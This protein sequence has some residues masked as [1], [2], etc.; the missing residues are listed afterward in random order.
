MKKILLATSLLSMLT[1]SSY[2]ASVQAGEYECNGAKYRLTIRA[3]LNLIKNGN[4]K[5]I[6]TLQQ[7]DGRVSDTYYK[8]GKWEE[9]GDDTILVTNFFDSD[10]TIFK[11][12]GKNLEFDANFASRDW[13]TAVLTCVKK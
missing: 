8:I 6:R 5:A 1:I 9:F 10:N 2:A 11:I 3:N 4:M 7:E 13:K 12:N